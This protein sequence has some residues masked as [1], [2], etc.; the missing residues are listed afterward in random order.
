MRSFEFL[1]RHLAPM[2][3]LLARLCQREALGPVEDAAL[4]LLSDPAGPTRFL[5]LA[6]RQGVQGLVLS[7]L[8]AFAEDQPHKASFPE[9]VLIPLSLLQRQ[10]VFW[11]LEQSRILS[12]LSTQGLDV[13]LLKGGAL[14]HTVYGSP[15]ERPMADLDFLVP[16]EEV[17]SALG[18]L[19]DL[20]YGSEYSDAAPAGFREHHYHERVTHANG[21]EVEVHWGLTRPSSPFG[22]NSDLFRLRGKHQEFRPGLAVVVPSPEDMA[23]HLVSQ[24]EHNRVRKLSRIVDLD[25]VIST[26]SGFD[27]EYFSVTGR[28]GRLSTVAAV[29]L[30][31]ANL[32]LGT[33]APQTFLRGSGVS[34]SARRNLESLQ[35]CRRLMDASERGRS[36]DNGL[37]RLWCLPTWRLRGQAILE[38]TS[39]AGDPLWWV[40]KEKDAPE[41]EGPSLRRGIMAAFKTL[42]YQVLVGARGVSGVLPGVRR[43]RAEFW[44]RHD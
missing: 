7:R 16:R 41:A 35:P 19:A 37:F 40:W 27:W 24:S 43:H 14:R 44:K 21:F 13:L 8:K 12:Y 30:R 29:T 9:S 18:A 5:D 17:S 2:E 23:L 31:L 11:E 39:G 36:V 1:R 42:A 38:M 6:Q 3:A 15:L 28:E 10:A 4:G 25:R 26:S 33:P 20:G 32:L 22:L 34:W